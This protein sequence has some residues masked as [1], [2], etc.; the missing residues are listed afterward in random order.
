MC[1][2]YTCVGSFKNIPAYDPTKICS[3]VTTSTSTKTL[4]TSIAPP[5][6]GK[7]GNDH[8][9]E[10]IAIFIGIPTIVA[11]LVVIVVCCLKHVR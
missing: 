8:H 3:V 5:S 9:S 10:P 11:V 6:P 4:S 2:F 1:T 7:K